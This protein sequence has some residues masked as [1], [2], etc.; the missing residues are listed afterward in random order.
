M[1]VVGAAQMKQRLTAAKAIEE[2]GG[3]NPKSSAVATTHPIEASNRIFRARVSCASNVPSNDTTPPYQPLNTVKYR[4]RSIFFRH[5]DGFLF[6][7]Y[8]AKHEARSGNCLLTVFFFLLFV[9]EEWRGGRGFHTKG[10]RGCSSRGGLHKDRTLKAFFFLVI[11]NRSEGGE[12]EGEGVRR[13]NQCKLCKWALSV[14]SVF[15][16]GGGFLGGEKVCFWGVL[17]F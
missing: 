8:S 12:G 11:N 1:T 10:S 2:L 6:G 9:F 14:V 3:C 17:G 7:G 4:E 5:P 15:F 16:F 13:I